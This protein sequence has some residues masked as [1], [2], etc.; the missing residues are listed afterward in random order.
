MSPELA[1]VLLIPLITGLVEAAKRSGFPARHAPIL[2]IGLGIAIAGGGYVAGAI[3]ADDA[4][5]AIIQ[6]ASYGLAASG[7]YSAARFVVGSPP[8][9][10][11]A[12]RSQG[13]H[14]APPHT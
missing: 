9:R 1:G 2:A 13:R 12:G 11:A 14:E 4:Y 3:G 10:H 5:R 7:L 8:Q 6:G